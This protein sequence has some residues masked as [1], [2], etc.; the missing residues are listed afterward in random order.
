M[1]LNDGSFSK[2]GFGWDIRSGATVGEIVQHTGSNPG[3]SNIIIR[4][5]DKKKTIIVL[6]NNAHNKMTE[7]VKN[8]EAEIIN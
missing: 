4:Y 3:I 8:I 7:L 5:I 1:K 6:C 2:Y